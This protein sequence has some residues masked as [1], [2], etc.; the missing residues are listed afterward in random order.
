MWT[1]CASC[2]L[3]ECLPRSLSAAESQ[4]EVDGVGDVRLARALPPAGP[5]EYTLAVRAA[6]PPPAL[7]AALPLHILIVEPDDAPPR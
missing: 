1:V 5:A 4:F 2:V 7:P 6:G 3:K